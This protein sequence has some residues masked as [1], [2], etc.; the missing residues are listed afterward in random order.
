[1]CTPW[2]KAPPKQ[3]FLHL[4][5]LETP[6]EKFLLRLGIALLR[7]GEPICLGLSLLRLGQVTVLVLFFL[8]LIVEFVNLLFRL[9]MEDIRHKIGLIEDPNK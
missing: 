3:R 9:P 8:Q 7:L 1:M 4:G 2:H 5:E 6:S